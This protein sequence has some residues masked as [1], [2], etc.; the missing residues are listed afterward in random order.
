MNKE[1]FD[2]LALA[3]PN[4]PAPLPQAVAPKE[5]GNSELRALWKLAERFANSDMVPPHFK[6]KV[7]NCFVVIQMA[8]R[9]GI[10][11][12]L[13]LQNIFMVSGR[14]G[15][16]AQLAIAL[17]NVSG[18]FKGPIR[19]DVKGEGDKLTVTA[20]A[21]SKEGYELSFTA[22]MA[23]AIAENWIK[24]PKYKSM[25]ELMLRYRAAVLLIRLHI[26]E[27]LMGMH[28]A[29]EYE[30]VSAAGSVTV[31]AE[32]PVASANELLGLK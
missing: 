8:Q 24:N 10:D 5:E 6:G 16:S 25:P 20:Y 30:D 15:M 14:P 7:D 2:K 32:K 23:M 9:S 3:H 4:V 29:D 1:D 17:A 31:Q 13:A 21:T 12:M 19:Y 28:M 11:P 27:V 26:P 22:S 18:Q